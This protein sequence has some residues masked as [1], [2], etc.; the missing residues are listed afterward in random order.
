MSHK[1]SEQPPRDGIVLCLVGPAG[2]GKT[3]LG[4]DLLARFPESI[5]YSI[6]AT[7]RDPRSGEQNGVH[8]H[9]FSRE[10][11]EQRKDAGEFFETEEVHGN[12]YGTLRASVEKSL[13]QGVDLLLDVD[14]KGALVFKHK[15]PLNTVIV[16]LAPP[17]REEMVQRIKA[18][19]TISDDELARRL[20]TANA[21]FAR[22]FEHSKF[23]G[24]IDY[25]IVNE[26]RDAALT[27]LSAILMA[28]RLRA[29]RVSLDSKKVLFVE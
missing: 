29:A 22:F 10:E 26:Q 14:I 21:E 23:G 24:M 8:Y 6:S 15:L 28:E 3:S 13:S 5:R 20:E 16:F 12:L 1:N 19:G 18:R 4:A 27:H 9:F 25:L 11:F 17:T 2:S 7:T